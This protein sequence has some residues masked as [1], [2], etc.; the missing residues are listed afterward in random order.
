MV[1]CAR[2]V[3]MRMK[4]HKFYFFFLS[5]RT[6]LH[7]YDLYY[8]YIRTLLRIAF[9]FFYTDLYYIL[10][11]DLYYMYSIYVLY[12]VLRFFFIQTYFIVCCV[13]IQTCTTCII[14]YFIAYCVFTQTRAAV[15]VTCGW[16]AVRLSTRGEW[17]CAVTRCGGPYATT[18]GAPMTLLWSVD[19]WDT[20][21][22]VSSA[23]P[24]YSIKGACHWRL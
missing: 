21:L 19:S 4:A 23:G 13:F 10:Y 8:M 20:L 11:T 14:M 18:P 3:K 16:W 15:M 22:R 24:E 12:C 5:K 2:Y 6:M 9:F 17:K 1:Y 7:K